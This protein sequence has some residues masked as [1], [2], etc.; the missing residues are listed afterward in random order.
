MTTWVLGAALAAAISPAVVTRD[1][2]PPLV[3]WPANTTAIHGQAARALA[4]DL[5]VPDSETILS[6]EPAPHGHMPGFLGVIFHRRPRPAAASFLCE[7][8]WVFVSARSFESPDYPGWRTSR[9]DDPAPTRVSVIALDVGETC[10]AVDPAGRAFWSVDWTETSNAIGR[11][12]R[13]RRDV[14][15]ADEPPSGCGLHPTCEQPF[16][17]FARLTPG[18]VQS[19]RSFERDG[20]TCAWLRFQVDEHTPPGSRWTIRI[21]DPSGHAYI[22]PE[23]TL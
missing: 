9:P 5:G 15:R 13:L 22:H 4:S 17:A 10:D 7:T 19:V 3:D 18:R 12:N 23:P 6:A 16:D 1:D 2:A 8:D 21:C 14:A 11:L 20:E